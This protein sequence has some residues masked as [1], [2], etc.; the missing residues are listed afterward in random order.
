MGDV[1][2]GSF[3]KDTR[4]GGFPYGADQGMDHMCG[5]GRAGQ[6]VMSFSVVSGGTPDAVV[7]ADIGL[8]NM[9]NDTYQVLVNG[10][11]VARVNVDESTKE[12]TGFSILGGGGGEVLNVMVGGTV[13]NQAV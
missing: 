4:E 2:Q 13:K 6:S 8:P 7:F 9:A 10:E 1:T 3:P 11:T 12:V 5:A